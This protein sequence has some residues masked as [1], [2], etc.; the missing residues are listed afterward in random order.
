[1]TLRARIAVTAA[2]AV[3]LAFVVAAGAVYLTT[4]RTLRGEVDRSLTVI[5]DDLASGRP[6]RIANRLAGSRQG[7]LG[8]AGGF[9]QFVR[10][11]GEVVGPDLDQPRL[12]FDRAVTD[13]AAGERDPFL[14]TVEVRR[15]PVRVLTIGL[16]DDLAAQVARPLDEVEDSLAR[17]RRRLALGMLLAV[18]LA[19][20]LGMLV[21]RRAV[22]P[23]GRLTA[24][25]EEVAAT[26]DLSR[27]IALD[28]AG[29]GDEL[30][31]LARTFNGMLANLEQARLAQ[32][33]L[34]ADASH[35]LRTP[36]T[37]LRTNIEVLALDA[38][39]TDAASGDVLS[40]A[41]RRRLLDDLTVQL[42][43]FG[44]LVGALVELTRG[45]RPS[46]AVTRVRLDEVVDAAVDRARA[47]AGPDQRIALDADPV[48]VDGD[49]ERI[50]RAVANLLDNAV[51]YGRGQPIDVRVDRPAGGAAARVVVR[52][53]GPGIPDEHRG[54]VFE[55]F[56]RA[57]ETRDAPGSGLGL[58]IVA[59]VAEAHGGAVDAAP[60]DG[61]G[62]VLT[63][64]LPASAI[65][66]TTS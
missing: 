36:L 18:A 39:A 32:Q 20:G 19:A 63:L 53:R 50:D 61:D 14:T 62:T 15:R 5:A 40:H 49:A 27:R 23:V 21:A 58:A 3:A 54:R 4:A 33:Q 57:P 13:V 10:A 41:D 60:A 55:R 45:A 30:A 35:E 7:Y 29:D 17:L 6:G 31:R 24:V 11:D 65:D 52:D 51:K 37:S 34:V 56:Y 46:T 66:G 25:A 2:A 1:V 9:V 59:Q 38:S 12:P 64:R 43:E 47:F 28:R 48:T 26:G 16:R 8:G 22:R 42:D 44:R